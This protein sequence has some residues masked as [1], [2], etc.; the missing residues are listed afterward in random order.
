MPYFYVTGQLN[1]KVLE[2]LDKHIIPALRNEMPCKYSEQELHNDPCLARF[3]VV[4]D[5]EAYSPVFFQKLWDDY[6]IAVLTY[7]KNV[8]DLWDENDFAEYE[9]EI[10]GNTSKMQ[11][12]EKTVELNGVPM[13]EVRRLCDGHQTSVIT[14]N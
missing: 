3:T 7:R 10:E 9:V 11:L 8:K 2:M 1:E 14:T 12:A 5:R 13:R 4:F 6:R